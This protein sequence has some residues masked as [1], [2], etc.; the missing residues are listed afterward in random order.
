MQ[1]VRRVYEPGSGQRDIDSFEKVARFRIFGWSIVGAFLGFLLGV[2]LGVQG[3]AGAGVVLLMTL[4]GWA[5]AYFFPIF[6][7]LVSR[8]TNSTTQPELLSGSSGPSP[9]PRCRPGRSF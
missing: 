3:A 6:G 9:T 7:L 1:P 5:V 4:T 2:F 8:E